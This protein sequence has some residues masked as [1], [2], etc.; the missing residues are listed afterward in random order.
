[1]NP[2]HPLNV[3]KLVF[4]MDTG[5]YEFSRREEAEEMTIGRSEKDACSM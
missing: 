2:F 4:A 3:G 1:L 5:T